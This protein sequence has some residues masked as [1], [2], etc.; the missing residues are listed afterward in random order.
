LRKAAPMTTRASK[1]L[2][3]AGI[4]LFYSLVVFDNLTDFDSNYQFV[5]HVLMMD[6]TFPGNNGMWRALTSPALHL[7]FYFGIIAWEICTAFLLWWGVARLLL[8]LRLAAAEYN[9][10]K[11]VPV[12]AL[13]LSLLMWL[14]AFLA[15]GGEWFLMW[16]S[17]TWNGQEA[18]F[19]NF[20]VVG[21][22]LLI[23]L[24]PDTDLQP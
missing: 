13:T 3:L 2:L 22:V 11:R 5:R 24:Q 19:R 10:A 6:T 4:A 9:F 7:A 17:R 14:V 1:I 8:S 12:I 16:Q 18:A 23:L 20:L 21:L 15:V